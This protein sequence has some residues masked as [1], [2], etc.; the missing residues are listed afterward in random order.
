MDAKK[1]TFYLP[2]KALRYYT[3]NNTVKLITQYLLF[4]LT[5]HVEQKKHQKALIHLQQN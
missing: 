2:S 3:L 4:M 1:K 5:F